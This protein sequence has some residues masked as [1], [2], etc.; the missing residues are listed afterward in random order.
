MLGVSILFKRNVCDISQIVKNNVLKIYSTY[1]SNYIPI[2][3]LVLKIRT[4]NTINLRHT[5]SQTKKK[6]LNDTQHHKPK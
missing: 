1:N 6:T 2:I 4:E 3:G 5:A